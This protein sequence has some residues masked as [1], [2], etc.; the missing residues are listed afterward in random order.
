M[1]LHLPSPARLLRTWVDQVLA[2]VAKR[3][4]GSTPGA[5]FKF[6]VEK[7][8]VAKRGAER[9]YRIGDFKRCARN[10]PRRRRQRH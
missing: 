5:P 4:P 6:T 9:L 8:G 10:R 7:T 1:P 2:D 3:L